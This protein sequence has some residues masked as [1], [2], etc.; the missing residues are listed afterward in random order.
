MP[1]LP[2]T[3]GFVLTSAIL[4]VL[5]DLTGVGWF[6]ADN[7]GDRI[8]FWYVFSVLDNSFRQQKTEKFYTPRFDQ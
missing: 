3:V 2:K 6:A 7:F 1:H 5:T 4:S 8:V